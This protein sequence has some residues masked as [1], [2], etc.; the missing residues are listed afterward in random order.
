MTQQRS[1]IQNPHGWDGM[2]LFR[3]QPSLIVSRES[4][5]FWLNRPLSACN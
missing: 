4:G 2:L 1:P 3:A 5:D